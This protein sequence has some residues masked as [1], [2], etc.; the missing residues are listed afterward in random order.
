MAWRREFRQA[1][2]SF[3]AEMRIFLS[4]EALEKEDGSR[5]VCAGVGEGRSLI[6]ARFE[7]DGGPMR[8]EVICGRGRRKK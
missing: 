1:P 6:S 3:K 7:V 5:A 2:L 8:R 4:M